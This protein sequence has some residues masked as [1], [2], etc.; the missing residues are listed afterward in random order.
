MNPLEIE[1][2]DS[3]DSRVPDWKPFPQKKRACPFCGEYSDPTFLRPDN[4]PVS[5][6]LQCRCFYVSARLD[7]DALNAFYDRYWTDTCPRPL[8]D[9]MAHYLAASAGNRAK[10]DHCMQRI[11]ALSGAWQNRNVLDVGCGFGEKATMMKALGASVTGLDISKNAVKFM[12]EKLEIEAYYA[13]IEEFE[14]RKDFF[15]IVTMFEFV[16]HPLDPLSVLLAVLYKM[17][18]GGL[19]AI[20]T[21]NGTAG[22]RRISSGK[23]DWIGFRVDLEHMQ[24]LNV[25]TIHFLSHLLGCRIL[26]LEQFGFRPLE[27]ISKPKKDVFTTRTQW[28]RRCIKSIPGVRKTVYALRDLQTRRRGAGI[29]SPDSGIYHLFAVLQKME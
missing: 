9:E 4:L 1:K 18:P 16:E 20:V 26:H 29:P 11:G 21:P 28:L 23:N 12:S 8:T 7:D 24:Y 6:C 22:E 5:Q 2:L 19:L 17:R 25:E 10:S 14:G 3:L 15:D 27:D 13:V